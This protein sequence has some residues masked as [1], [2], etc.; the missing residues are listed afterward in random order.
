MAAAVEIQLRLCAPF[1]I[2]FRRIII[3]SWGKLMKIYVH[4][5]ERR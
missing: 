5:D 3:C 4:E 2:Y 1:G